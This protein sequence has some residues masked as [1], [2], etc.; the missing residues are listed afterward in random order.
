M[1]A[2]LRSFVPMVRAA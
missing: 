2:Y 1:P